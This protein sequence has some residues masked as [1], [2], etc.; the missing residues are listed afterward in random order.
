M[1][2]DPVGPNLRKAGV[3]HDDRTP[4]RRQ[5]VAGLLVV[6]IVLGSAASGV[7]SVPAKLFALDPSLSPAQVIRL[8]KQ[9]A[10]TTA[11]GRRHPVDQDGSIA[12]LKTG[13]A[14]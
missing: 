4:G 13:S 11:D 1:G 3:G 12:L 2:R 7:Y 6:G 8:I 9:S 10:I 14:R 5:R